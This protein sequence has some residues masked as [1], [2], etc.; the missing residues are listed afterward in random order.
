[1]LLPEWS[2]PESVRTATFCGGL[3][4]IF[5]FFSA[6][7]I[8]ITEGT[9][10]L[11]EN[12]GGF[13]VTE[14]GVVNIKVSVGLLFVLFCWCLIVRMFVRERA[15]WQHTGWFEKLRPAV[16]FHNRMPTCQVRLVQ[17]FVE[18]IACIAKVQLSKVFAVTRISK[19]QQQ[20]ETYWSSLSLSFGWK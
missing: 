4:V 9:K 10:K 14:R 2:Q 7:K 3:K 13:V 11:L 15:T 17:D 1:M 20:D 6:T 19:E 12:I 8:Q 16:S 5:T 18:S